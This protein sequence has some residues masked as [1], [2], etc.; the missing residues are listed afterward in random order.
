MIPDPA[1]HVVAIC[2]SLRE[3]SYTRM[4]LEISLRGAAENG[5][6]TH[7]IDL[8]DYDLPF[9]KDPRARRG[10]N[11]VQ[12][13]REDVSKAQ[14]IVLGTPN[15][16]GSYSGVLKNAL[17][18]MGFEEFEGRVV[19]LVGVAGG[20][21]GA[22][23]PLDALRTVSRALHAWTIPDEASIP[24][25][26]EVFSPDGTCNDRLA[27]Q[28]LLKVGQQVTRFAALHHAAQTQEFLQMWEKSVENPGG[29]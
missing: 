12:R 5:A 18:L 1:V 11:D 9:C 23:I 2:G 3:V 22:T 27:E 26:R 16:H 28:R 8:I 13:L 7:L 10:H 6:T 14:G 20:A 17:D 25:V 4:A 29:D 19:G 15:Y 21:T 24:R